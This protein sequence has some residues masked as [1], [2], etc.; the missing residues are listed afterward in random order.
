MKY[1]CKGC[2]RKGGKAPPK[3]KKLEPISERVELT[4]IIP[5][6]V[7]AQCASGIHS[8]MVM[9]STTSTTVSNHILYPYNFPIAN[10]L[11]PSHSLFLNPTPYAAPMNPSLSSL[12]SLLPAL[13]FTPWCNS[14]YNY[15]TFAFT[16]RSLFL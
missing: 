8:S 13:P 10:T 4:P 15:S 1:V 9:A 2:G 5:S 7:D 16:W 14:S 12:H 3:K 11:A 6:P